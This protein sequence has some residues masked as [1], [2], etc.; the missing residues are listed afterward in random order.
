MK[1]LREMWLLAL[2]LIPISSGALWAQDR[3][4]GGSVH[5]TF[6]RLIE[7]EMDQG[8]LMGV[9]VKPFDRDEPL[10][11]LV[12][13]DNEDLRQA[14]RRMH[15]GQIIEIAF[16]SEGGNAW[17]RRLEA[18]PPREREEQILNSA[19]GQLVRPAQASP[20][21]DEQRPE[22]RRVRIVERQVRRKPGPVEAP[23]EARRDRPFP[24]DEQREHLRTRPEEPQDPGPLPELGRMQEE[25]RDIV[26]G[27][28]EDMARAIRGVLQAHFEQ[29]RAEI[30]ELHANMERMEGQMQEL[31]AENERLR[32]QLRERGER[33]LQ[34]ERQIREQTEPQRRR[35]SPEAQERRP[36]RDRDR[37]NKPAPPQQ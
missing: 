26:V 35:P 37:G 34:R 15:K 1:K 36:Q 29:M 8:Q 31:R 32:T 7:R 6:V 18:Q 9:V 33:G 12:P 13:W 2:L 17:L 16:D 21:R 30:R 11:V 14:A 20:E 4:R 23:P 5:G 22:G 28:T 10:T 25:L 19:Q 3:D 27:H 24:D